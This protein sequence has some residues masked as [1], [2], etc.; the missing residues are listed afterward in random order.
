ML[1]APNTLILLLGATQGAQAGL[2][3]HPVR[4]GQQVW[5]ALDELRQLP[6]AQVQAPR[7]IREGVPVGL[8]KVKQVLR[9]PREVWVLRAKAVR[10]PR[11]YVPELGRRLVALI[12]P[13]FPPHAHC[14]GG[15]QSPDGR[16]AVLVLAPSLRGCR[17]YPSGEGRQAHCRARFVSVLTPGPRRTVCFDLALRQQLIVGEREKVLLHSSPSCLCPPAHPKS[18]GPRPPARPSPPR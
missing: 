13:H 2:G 12:D 3:A 16:P 6:R 1:R 10:A 5:A 7:G 9:P 15:P 17:R 11:Q 14:D 18:P 4:S 8:Q